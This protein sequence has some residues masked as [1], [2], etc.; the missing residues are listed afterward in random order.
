[1]LNRSIHEVDVVVVDVEATGLSPRRDRLVE[2]GLVRGQAGR[3]A[4]RFSSLVDPGRAMGATEVHGITATMVA[5]EPRAGVVLGKLLPRLEGA[6]LVGHRVSVDLRFLQTE[7]ARWGLTVPAAPALDTAQLC[8]RF[9]VSARQLGS[10]CEHFGVPTSGQHRALVD[11]EATW[12]LLWA[13]VAALE[14]RGEAV[15][16]EALAAP[17]RAPIP[18]TRDALISRLDL[19]I[20]SRERLPIRYESGGPGGA[21]SDREITPLRLGRREL[22]AWCHLREAERTFRIDRI[23][24]V[25]EDQG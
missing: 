8:R 9:D 23:Q 1:M 12:G 10:L 6:V 20:R 24:L 17:T 13:M 11:A 4:E 19:A 14:A 2:V 25:T 7:A 15:T 16:I 18:E 5:G 3:I 21:L 22:R